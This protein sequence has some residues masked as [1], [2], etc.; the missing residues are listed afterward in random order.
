MIAAF[1]IAG[2]ASWFQPS[3]AYGIKPVCAMNVMPPGSYVQIVD[4][5]NGRRANC[6]VIGTGPFV[7][8]RVID[9]SPSVRDELGIY[10]SGIAPVR[11]Y[12]LPRPQRK[13]LDVYVKF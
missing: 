1:I 6:D 10:H 12:E 5:S 2:L 4:E 8:G 7:P 13:P 3:S 11:V 9:V